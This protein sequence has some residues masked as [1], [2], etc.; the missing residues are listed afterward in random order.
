MSIIE[1][2]SSTESQ[3]SYCQNCVEV[4]GEIKALLRGGTA[5]QRTSF[6]P[7]TT[8]LL[9]PKT[10]PL[11]STIAWVLRDASSLL[12]QSSGL[13]RLRTRRL[14]PGQYTVVFD[15]EI[16]GRDKIQSNY[17]LLPLA[18]GWMPQELRFP[19]LSRRVR[20]SGFDAEEVKKWLAQ[21]DKSHGL[22]CCITPDPRLARIG[23]R[24]IDTEQNCLVRVTA[25]CSY[26][27]LTY[28]WG[29]VDQP[30]LKNSL[31]M[32]WET[33]G[34]FLKMHLPKTIS[35]AIIVCRM[36]GLKYLWVDSLCIVQDNP[37]AVQEQI[38][39]MNLVY[40]QAYLTIV[41][42]SGDDCDSGLPSV[43]AREPIQR[44]FQAGDLSMGTAFL[45][46]KQEL[47]KSK[48]NRRAWTLQ[49][50]TLSCRCLVFTPRQVFFCCAEGIRR[51]D[52]NGYLVEGIPR[53]DLFILPVLRDSF[54][55]NRLP[56]DLFDKVYVPLVEHYA[57]RDTSYASDIL[58]AFS[59]VTGV[60]EKP[61][62]LGEFIAGIPVSFISTGLT[63]SFH[64]QC[65]RRSGFPS[66]SWAG[67]TFEPQ[68][69]GTI[70]SQKDA[71]F[72]YLSQLGQVRLPMHTF[73]WISPQSV[74]SIVLPYSG[75]QPWLKWE[76][77]GWDEALRL[78]ARD[79]I[80]E[81]VA[82]WGS[83]GTAVTVP[84]SIPGGEIQNV[85][86][87]RSCYAIL[88]VSKYRSFSLND[89]T[90]G[91]FRMLFILMLIE[92][93]HVMIL[94]VRRDGDLLR[95]VDN[96]QLLGDKEWFQKRPQNCL[97]HLA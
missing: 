93:P 23:M 64:G 96:P 25:H 71:G 13:V 92:P 3:Q 24:L 38:N 70:I 39:N 5:S 37:L 20:D 46:L 55:S 83:A 58:K 10:C 19:V 59:G 35:D 60:L 61:I 84:Q 17:I 89:A 21:C 2:M 30:V 41:A 54:L 27:A 11:C 68:R 14:R 57:T 91:T 44:I 18:S 32:E 26:T 31:I 65:S 16:P 52:V 42:A 69:Q 34:H 74:R 90:P 22:H 53:Q 56:R 48:W 12:L 7:W 95:R 63:W 81:M 9:Q 88:D 50:Y 67:W 78:H 6:P 73:S 15:L 82:L 66:W 29:P 51:E 4:V 94:P 76:G 28:V 49:E 47:V 62:Y 72:H 36:I 86:T 1:N 75:F 87:F 79:V 33:P 97:V 85:L 77:S 40:S 8:Y 80:Q 43:Q 45:S